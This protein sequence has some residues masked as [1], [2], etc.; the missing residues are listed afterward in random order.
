MKKTIITILLTM[1]ATSA[2]FAG[3]MY[4]MNEKHIEEKDVILVEWD[5]EVA[6]LEDENWELFKQVEMLEGKYEDSTEEVEWVEYLY[7]MTL[8]D[9]TEAESEIAELESYIAE[10][11][12]Q[13]LN[14]MEGRPYEV[15][16]VDSDGA[17]HY[18]SS[19]NDGLFKTVNHSKIY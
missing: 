5:S 14:M 19:D 10:N 13:I 4:K 17:V 11:E 8:D 12:E 6:A 18:W 16:A 7:H 9:Y 3:M 15:R 1:V 2:V